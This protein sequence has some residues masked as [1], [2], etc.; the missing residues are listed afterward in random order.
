MSFLAAIPI[1]GDLFEKVGAAIDRNVTTDDERL[2]AKTEL[3]GLFAP[4]IQAVVM[5]QAAF[6]E[7]QAK[8]AGIEAKSEHWLVWSRRPIVS[9]FA[10]ANFVVI[11]WLWI[12]SMPLKVAF[13][14]QEVPALVQ[15]AFYFAMAANG[16]DMT[17]RGVEKIV[18]A[19]KAKEEV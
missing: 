2:K 16:L 15:F 17:T 10:A 6:A 1:I 7:L 9:L 12:L 5:A 14:T 4:V 18:K 19:F 8:L 3:T 11:L 13:Y